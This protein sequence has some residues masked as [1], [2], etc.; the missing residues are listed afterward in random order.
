MDYFFANS[1]IFRPLKKNFCPFFT[2]MSGSKTKQVQRNTFFLFV[3]DEKSCSVISKVLRISFN[4]FKFFST[5]Q[6]SMM[7]QEFLYVST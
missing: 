2:F 5:V 6:S 4:F 7:M 3:F 1:K